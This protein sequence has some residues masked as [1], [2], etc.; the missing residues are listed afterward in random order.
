MITTTTTTTISAM[1]WIAN[2]NS[3]NNNNKQR[4]RRRQQQY[5]QWHEQQT[6]TIATTA[7]TKTTLHN[8]YTSW[9]IKTVLQEISSPDEGIS[10]RISRD[11]CDIGFS[12]EIKHG[13]HESLR[14]W[15]F[16]E[17]YSLLFQWN[18]ILFHLHP[19]IRVNFAISHKASLSRVAIPR[20][21]PR[22]G[23]KGARILSAMRF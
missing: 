8:K 12:S 18:K 22:L 3:D 11:S 14:L 23:N 13:T 6:T 17:S 16:L 2:D 15:I 4:P 5:Q 20:W 9:F 7:V 10:R 19:C 21:I 1:T